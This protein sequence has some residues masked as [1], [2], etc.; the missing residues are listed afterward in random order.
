MTV[1]GHM[2]MSLVSLIET[3][4]M[5]SNASLHSYGTFHENF[6]EKLI[7]LKIVVLIW[8]EEDRIRSGTPNRI[9]PN[10]NETGHSKKRKYSKA[11]NL[12]WMSDHLQESEF[13]TYLQVNGIN[14]EGYEV[15]HV[16]PF[17]LIDYSF[18]TSFNL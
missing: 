16:G 14:C 3:L 13:M 8:G 2:H 1:H 15:Q 17:L 9:P 12:D 7:N 5:P 18:F 4:T 6:S 11:S 10:N